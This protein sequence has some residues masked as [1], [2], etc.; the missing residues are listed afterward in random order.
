MFNNKA[1]PLD[2]VTISNIIG[3]G[4]HLE[5][6]ISTTGN[7]RVEGKVTGG[8]QT[9]AKVVLSHTAQLQ[10]NIVAQNAEIGGEVKGTIE[11]I[12][13]LV[14][15]STAVVWG[16]II[17]SKLVFE[18]GAYFDGKCKM[19]KKNKE[20]KT[21]HENATSASVN[22]SSAATKSFGLDKEHMEGSLKPENRKLSTCATRPTTVS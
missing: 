15:K 22:V 19:G 3:Q 13:L 5:G 20:S 11:V 10:G 17:A 4:S 6:N 1:K 18:E 8:I 7:L 16:D 14:L 21:V 2:P 9:K 12:E